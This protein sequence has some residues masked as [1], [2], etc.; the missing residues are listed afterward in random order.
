MVME[1]LWKIVTEFGARARANRELVEGAVRRFLDAEVSRCKAV[2]YGPV[3][4]TAADSKKPSH[5][6]M[7]VFLARVHDLVVAED[8][9]GD[10]RENREP[11]FPELEGLA[12]VVW[13][14]LVFPEDL[15]AMRADLAEKGSCRASDYLAAVRVDLPLPAP[16]GQP[17]G[18]AP[19]P[20][21]DA[22]QQEGSLAGLA[23]QQASPLQPPPPT[24]RRCRPMSRSEIARRLLDN[25]NGRPRGAVKMMAQY[26]LRDEGNGKY[27]VV[28]SGDMDVKARNRLL[29]PLG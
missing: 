12:E 27:T 25:P 19:T 2:K 26:G 22:G 24:E 9:D 21:P 4:P 10:R 15:S 16:T 17:E 14:L 29:A 5:D 28:I 11:L 8:R 23:A 20:P 3:L 18:G 6:E 7:I 1:D 13:S